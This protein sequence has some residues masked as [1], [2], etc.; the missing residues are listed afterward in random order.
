MPQAGNL[1]HMTTV[2]SQTT[3]PFTLTVLSHG[4][5]PRT[6]KPVYVLYDNPFNLADSGVFPEMVAAIEHPGLGEFWILN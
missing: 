6:L 2:A 1:Y 4:S 5:Q 3:D